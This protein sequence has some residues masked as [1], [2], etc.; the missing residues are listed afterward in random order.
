MLLVLW[1]CNNIFGSILLILYRQTQIFYG[2]FLSCIFIEF[3]LIL[4]AFVCIQL[5][6]LTLQAFLFL[7]KVVHF[8]TQIL[9][10][11]LKLALKIITFYLILILIF[12]SKFCSI[13][14]VET[15]FL[16][17]ISFDEILFYAL[18][19]LIILKIQILNIKKLR[20]RQNHILNLNLL[21]SLIILARIF[22]LLRKFL[23]QNT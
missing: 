5:S 9:F 8:I 19:I 20:R 11:P 1:S 10:F 21:L 6:T 22:H 15:I 7:F 13:D 23:W 18:L 4:V 17:W 12:E 14:I 16:I 2:Y 3:L